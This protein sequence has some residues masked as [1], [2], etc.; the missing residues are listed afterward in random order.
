[1][2]R[3]LSVGYYIVSPIVSQSRRLFFYGLNRLAQR[4]REHK[5]G[6]A[7]RFYYGKRHELLLLLLDVPYS[8]RVGCGGGETHSG[9]LRPAA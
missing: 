7:T 1:M 4:Q 6:K 8:S 3:Y 5:A 2:E 9:L